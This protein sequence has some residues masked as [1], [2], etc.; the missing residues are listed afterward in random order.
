LII[1]FVVINTFLNAFRLSH[2]GESLR[3]VTPF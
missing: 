2:D 1:L 3:F